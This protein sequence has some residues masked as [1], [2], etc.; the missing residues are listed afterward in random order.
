MT[1]Q[2]VQNIAV[3]AL[4][5][6]Q[7]CCPLHQAMR[8]QMPICYMYGTGDALVKGS[9]VEMALKQSGATKMDIISYTGLGHALFWEEPEDTARAI[10]GFVGKVWKKNLSG[11]WNQP[12]RQVEVN[13]TRVGLRNEA[14]SAVGARF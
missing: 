1:S 10:V 4:T 12:A 6:E 8:F 7:D 11:T 3:A 14:S 9:V 13:I 2:R 5:R